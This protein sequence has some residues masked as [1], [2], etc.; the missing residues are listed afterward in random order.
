M[1]DSNHADSGRG[2]VGPPD[3]LRLYGTDA[4]E[5]DQ[6]DALTSGSVPV[7]VYGLGKMGL[8]LAGVFAETTGNVVGVDVDESVVDAVNRGRAHVE[9]EPGID[10][11][12]AETVDA[13]AFRATADGAAAADDAALHVVV[14]PTLIDDDRSP[15]LSLLEAVLDDVAAGLDPGDAVFVESTVPPDTCRD[16]VRPSLAAASG[17]APDEFGVACCPERTASGRALRDIRRAYPKV[18]GGVDDESTRVAE[19]VYD[20]VT[21]ND[22]VAVSD[23]TTAAAVKLFEGL[24]RDVNIALA[25]ELARVRDDLA[26]D[27]TEAI[28]AANT[29]SLCDIHDPGAGVGG[30]CIPYYPSFVMSAVETTTPLLRTARRVNDGMPRFAVRKLREGL[31]DEG[32]DPADATVAVLGLTY[33][34]G[35]KETRATPAKPVVDALRDDGATVLAADP[36]LS[37]D[38]IRSFGARP[39]AAASLPDEDL[40]AAVLVTAHDALVAA[41]WDAMDPIVVVDGRDAL[42]LDGTR[43]RVYTVGRG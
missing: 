21:E 34:A 33:R 8:P 32:V 41:D 3:A 11:L 9:G 2:S 43:H 27:V 37:A 7:A 31:A 4:S 38:E 20:H 28:D 16:A 23:A 18:V 14:V 5:A 42:S 12:V 13:G 26:I 22:V 17:L 29:L 35:V 36:M 39:T 6:R 25:N 24:Y 19:L 30:H 1:S 10:G 15:D 40:D